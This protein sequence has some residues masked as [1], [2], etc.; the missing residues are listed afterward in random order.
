[1]DDDA[2][3]VYRT[4]ELAV[5]SRSRGVVG[6]AIF[7]DE[8]PVNAVKYFESTFNFLRDHNMNIVLAAGKKDPNTVAEAV[9]SGA[10]RISGGFLLHEAPGILAFMADRDIPVEISPSDSLADSTADVRVFAGHPLRL[11]LGKSELTFARC[12]I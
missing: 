4:A 7:K 3:A 5:E 12:S 2:V 8:M 11:Y 1:M 9:A 10:T 6:F